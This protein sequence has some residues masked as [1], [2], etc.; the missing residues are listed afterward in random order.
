MDLKLSVFDI[1][2]G[3]LWPNDHHLAQRE[4]KETRFYLHTMSPLYALDA[5]GERIGMT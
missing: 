2:V 3:R 5:Q 1:G 4:G